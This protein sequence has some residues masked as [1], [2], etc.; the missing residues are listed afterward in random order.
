MITMNN[1]V[2]FKII[3]NLN[4]KRSVDINELVKDITKY[5]CDRQDVLKNDDV[6]KVVKYVVNKVINNMID[7]NIIKKVD[8]YLLFVNKKECE[9]KKVLK[10]SDSF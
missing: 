6:Y 10:K 2:Y 3:N 4:K 9:K 5:Y 8:D 7:D 1:F